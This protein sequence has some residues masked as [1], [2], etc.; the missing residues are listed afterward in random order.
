MKES[1]ADKDTIKYARTVIAEIKETTNEIVKEVEV[2]SDFTLGIGDFVKIKNTTSTGKVVDVSNDGKIFFI[3]VG[4]LKMQVK[5]EDLI[6]TKEKEEKKTDDYRDYSIQDLDYRIDIR[7]AR[8]EEIEFDIVKFIDTAYTTS[9]NRVEILHGK[10]TGALK[11]TVR[12]LL[13]NHDKVKNFYFA[14][15]EYGGEGITIVEL[16]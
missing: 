10:G 12:E 7:G 8:P 4:K 9:V 6:P 3:L 15:V 5:K 11:K 16:M 13:S 14:P 2:S 1:N